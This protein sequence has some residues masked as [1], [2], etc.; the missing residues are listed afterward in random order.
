MAEERDS[1][2][3]SPETP[4][5]ARPRSPLIIGAIAYGMLIWMVLVVCLL[6]A[7]KLSTR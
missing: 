6:I 4:P 3:E 1:A 7:W 2:T 5:A